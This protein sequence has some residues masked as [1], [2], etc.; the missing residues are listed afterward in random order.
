MAESPTVPALLDRTRW[1][2]ALARQLVKDAHAAADLVQDAWVEGLEHRPSADRPLGG[3]LATVMRNR[4]TRLRRG[5]ANRAAREE[6]VAR[7]VALPSTLDVVA[8]AATH[9]DVVQAVLGLD[10]PYRRTILLRFFEQ[11][12]YGEIARQTGV[13]KATVNSRLTR[14]LA[15]LRLKLEANHGG[16]RRTFLAALAPL[17]KHGGGLTS[18]T[19]GTK[20]MTATIGITAWALVATTLS[21]GLTGSHGETNTGRSELELALPARATYTEANELA[22]QQDRR[23]VQTRPAPAQEEHG[24]EHEHANGH[25]SRM[26]WKTEV[27]HSQVL[28]P[29]IETL[30][31][32]TGAGSVEIVESTTGQLVIDAVVR[33]D[34]ERVR[35][36]LLTH[37]FDDHVELVEDGSELSIEE[38]HE[39]QR[40]IQVSFVVHV[41]KAL[42]VS[43]NSGAGSVTIRHASGKVTAN[44]GA[45]K[46]QVLL[47]D[48][49]VADLSANSGAGTVIVEI[50]R[51]EKRVTVNSGAG[52]VRLRVRD[53]DSPGE[54][55]LN[56]GAGS[57]RLV[58]PANVTG[59]FDAETDVGSI[60]LPA[61]FGI[62]VEREEYGVGAKAKGSIGQGTGTYKL[63]SGAGSI[64]ISYEGQEEASGK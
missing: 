4:L 14:G 22:A 34:T 44:S 54:A 62:A 9:R 6:G 61:G 58:V 56:S 24:Q 27:T 20:I 40:G 28:G 5:D 37:A 39:N 33:A 64:V 2:Q 51:V 36:E 12:S 31:V 1:I 26:D 11:S 21:V 10:E 41:P 18:L 63:R 47:K 16:D 15:L 48:K 13:T 50:G 23:P 57:V 49:T 17:A 53:W 32:K 25:D 19:L 42:A 8:K 29:A 52:T 38:R 7:D 30:V 60:R 59:R 55:A 35:P 45:G 43:A 46:V 3:W